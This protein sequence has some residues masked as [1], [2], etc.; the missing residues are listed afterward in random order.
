MWGVDCNTL[1]SVMIVSKLRNVCGAPELY[2]RECDALEVMQNGFGRWL[3]EVG[4][5]RNE[6]AREQSGWSSIVEREVNGMVD[7]LIMIVYEESIVSD[8]GRACLRDIG[9]KL[10]ANQDLRK[11]IFNYA[12][13][14]VP[15][16][17]TG[18]VATLNCYAFKNIILV[19]LI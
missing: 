17:V 7:C 19:F 16:Q 13:L 14:T 1:L 2:Q 10:F 12:E 15:P 3:W 11:D 4:K 6:L 9:Y 18:V 5:V 8:I